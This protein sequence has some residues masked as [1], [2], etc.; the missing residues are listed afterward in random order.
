V[1]V[2]A[3]AVLALCRFAGADVLLKQMDHQLVKNVQLIVN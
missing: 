2:I 3:K 1:G